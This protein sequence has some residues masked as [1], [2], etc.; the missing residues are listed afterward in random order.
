LREGPS[1]K[2]D[3]SVPLADIP[4]FIDVVCAELLTALPGIR[5]CV[6]GHVGDGNLHFNLQ[7]PAGMDEKTYATHAENIHA[8][9]YRHVGAMKGSVSA[10]HG[11]GQVKRSQLAATKDPHA[12]D[13]MRKIK[14]VIDPEGRMNPGK[15][16]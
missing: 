7:A 9:V 15:V 5:P 2:H 13:L 1:I 11:V 3:I 8:I 12:L 16:L 6:F 14:A 10:E 4:E